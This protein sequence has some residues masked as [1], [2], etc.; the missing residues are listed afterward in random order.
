[1][2]AGQVGRVIVQT[3]SVILLSRLLAPADFGVL[4]MVTA[5]IGVGALLRDFGLGQAAVQARHIT[6]EQKS[7]LLWINVGVG[8]LV[9]AM[10]WA[11]APAIAGLYKSPELTPVIQ[12]LSATF[13]LGG[14]S[15]QFR[16]ELSRK[17][18]FRG[19]ITSEV[20]AQLLGVG[21]AVA[22]AILGW[23]YWAL[24]A[25][26]LVDAF[27]L[28]VG[29]ILIARWRPSLPT[30]QPMGELL[31]FG[32]GLL[33]TQV[34][35][36]VS[37]NIDSFLIGTRYG[38]TA[39]GYYNRAFQLLMLPLNQVSAPATKVALP[40]L[41]R[42]Q[43][44][45]ERFNNFLLRANLLVGF[46]VVA[47]LAYAASQASALVEI[48]LGPQWSG[49][50]LFFQVLAVAG[51]F[52]SLSY[53]TYWVFLARGRTV[54]NLRFTLLTRSLVALGLVIASSVSVEAIAVAYSV[55]L[56]LCWPA[57]L[58]WI[59]RWGP[60]ARLALQGARILSYGVVFA[61]ASW[62]ST[63]AFRF[64]SAWANLALGAVALVAA[65]ALLWLLFPG[66]RRDLRQVIHSAHLVRG[67][68]HEEKGS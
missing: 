53:A 36:Y 37:Q 4:A 51:C 18:D 39:L 41:A 2:L 12:I 50:V 11:L 21:C 34:V 67:R 54:S 19:I 56:M 47:G 25:Q 57:G 32:W 38:A 10:V 45:A 62:S 58:W 68:R 60:S 20:S 23:G 61:L 59:R 14:T 15:T 3:T 24:V 65:A 44:D 13:F 46:F 17:M 35:L 31:R 42:V 9:A 27:A 66:V 26:Q 40:V 6:Q 29:S 48:I 33:G 22:L 8:A 28:L 30:R 5:V 7:N 1:M 52:Q 63:L 43:D 64:D 16:A 55:G 49:S